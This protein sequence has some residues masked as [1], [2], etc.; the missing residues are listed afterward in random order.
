MASYPVGRKGAAIM[1]WKFN[2]WKEFAGM[3][4]HKAVVMA[5]VGMIGATATVWYL[6]EPAARHYYTARDEAEIV[7]AVAERENALINKVLDDWAPLGQ[8]QWDGFDGWQG[9]FAS[10]NGPFMTNAIGPYAQ[11]SFFF[12][13]DD[14]VPTLWRINGSYADSRKWVDL[15][16][17]SVI[18][19]YEGKTFKAVFGTSPSYTNYPY[20]IEAG[21]WRENIW[22]D[23]DNWFPTNYY[24]TATNLHA[25]GKALSAG[26]HTIDP[27]V[28]Y[29]Y[30]CVAGV[31]WTNDTRRPN[32]SWGSVVAVGDG[33]DP[34]EDLLA[35]ALSDLAAADP[36][37]SFYWPTSTGEEL[38][39]SLPYSIV[40]DHYGYI[41]VSESG[42]SNPTN[43]T[44]TVRLREYVDAYP[45]GAVTVGTN[46]IV[47]AAGVV[48]SYGGNF[49]HGSYSFDEPVG[50]VV[51]P[52]DAPVAA[53][54]GFGALASVVS[55]A[56]VSFSKVGAWD[57]RFGADPYS[58]YMPPDLGFVPDS[59][60]NVYVE[61]GW[62]TIPTN[63][64]FVI[65]WQFNHLTNRGA[66]WP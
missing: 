13:L 33:N 4:G 10:T 28:D 35:E 59:G 62:K 39:A 50:L 9:L 1:A 6:R 60:S 12:W 64:A 45:L 40:F 14:Y 23:S 61:F 30:F 41:S 66:F 21:W 36:E 52:C 42:N 57:G 26:R 46:C 27:G 22:A 3:G 18:D 24:V 47:Y 43:R 16:D 58:A 19:A 29:N 17:L 55:N 31:G 11:S 65:D 53:G 49:Y 51:E 63:H 48:E 25:V 37:P 2:N 38:L 7:A 8:S 5:V 20:A 56:F 44:R 32:I 15:G 54:E 34:F